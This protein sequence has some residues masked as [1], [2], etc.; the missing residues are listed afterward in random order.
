MRKIVLLMF[1]LACQNALATS[2][3]TLDDSPLEDVKR[4]QIVKVC[5]DDVCQK[6]PVVKNIKAKDKPHL[7]RIL[8]NAK[9]VA[10]PGVVL[11]SLA[12]LPGA[13]SDATA[14][15]VCTVICGLVSSL[16][17][18]AGTILLAP[19]SPAAQGLYASACGY[20]TSMGGTIQGCAKGCVDLVMME[21]GLHNFG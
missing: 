19:L 12:N 16:G 2:I 8:A 6:L 15:T 4:G 18:T 9:K 14:V 7:E 11:I 20:L 17:C 13:E 3:H 21:G 1:T 10:V 5:K